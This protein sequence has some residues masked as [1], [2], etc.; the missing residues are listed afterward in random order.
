MQL[1]ILAGGLGT[2]LREETEFKPKPMVEIGNRP[3]I[4]HI[5][6]SFAS[7]GVSEFVVCAGYRG[8]VIKDYFL[9]YQVRTSDFRVLLASQP[10]VELV[11][12]TR[13]PGWSVT[14]VDTGHNT[15][16][17]GRLRRVEEHVRG[18][19]FMVAYG[20]GLSDLDVSSMVHFHRSHGRTATV[21]AVRPSSRFGVMDLAENG[22]VER[23]REKPQMDDYVNA[24]MFVF[25]RNIFQYLRD[26]DTVLEQN[27]LQ[28]LA[29][30]GELVAFRHESFWQPM[31]T[32]REYLLLNELWSSGSAP[33]RT[34]A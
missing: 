14:V 6:N 20:D 17:G 32:Y 33:W 18:D 24:G 19:T 13:A 12:E 21:A 26:D 29:S 25:N 11:G 2:R 22:K 34:R 16:T 30:E 31:D 10:T 27:P 5:M 9:N 23:F 1:I 7:H 15:M 8:D 4:W 28:R 3:I